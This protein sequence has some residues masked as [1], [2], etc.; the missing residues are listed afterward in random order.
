MEIRSIETLEWD[1]SIQEMKFQMQTNFSNFISAC[2]RNTQNVSHN[3]FK[4]AITNR[5]MILFYKKGKNEA[6]KIFKNLI[7]HLKNKST[8]KMQK[9]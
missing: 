6:I 8:V 1:K 3:T 2:F 7:I 5:T 9:F 4:N